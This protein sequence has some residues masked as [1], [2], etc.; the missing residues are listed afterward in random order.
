MGSGTPCDDTDRLLFAAATTI[1]IGDGAKASFWDS[2]WLEGRRLKDVAPLIYAASKKKNSTLQ[3][4]STTDQWLLD[5][6]LPPAS[7]WTTE[8]VSQLINV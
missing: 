4:A 2:A 5:L 6:D 8:L 7:G 3:Q 1:T